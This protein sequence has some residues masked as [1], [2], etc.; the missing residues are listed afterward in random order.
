MKQVLV[1]G[2][3]LTARPL[4]RYLLDE[5]AFRVTLA[6]L[7]LAEAAGLVG[8]HQRGRSL[9]IDVMRDHQTLGDLVAEAELV[10]S[11]L[12]V[13]C[14]LQVAEQCVRLRRPLVTANYSSGLLPLHT[15]AQR[16]GV[17]LLCETGLDP[18]IDHMLAMQT[19]DKVHRAGGEVRSLRCYCGGLP[20]PESNDNPLGYKFSWTPRGVAM[21][22]HRDGRFKERGCVVEV[23]SSRVFAA[24][25][26]I[27]VDGL[28][29]F[30][31]YPNHDSLPYLDHYDIPEADTIYR[32]AVRNL[33]WCDLMHKLSQLGYFGLDPRPDL[34]GQTYR[35]VT[36]ALCDQ[37]DAGDLRTAAA[38]L[39]GISRES[40]VVQAMD[41][42]G[43]FGETEIPH[44]ATCLLDALV[45]LQIPRMSFRPG[46]RDMV[47]LV[48]EVEAE[49]P[50]HK[51][52]TTSTLIEYGETGGDSAMARTVG[53]TAAIAA[54]QILRGAVKTTGVQI[55]VFPEIY[56]PTL[57]ELD[58]QGISSVDS[59]E[60][61]PC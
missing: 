7:D 40:A 45:A 56:G 17:L 51:E 32:G 18:G 5:G 34:G 29:D 23:P 6:A 38:S 12:P 15:D 41:W 14:E 27:L 30:E 53:L 16:A 44:T 47:I 24:H 25:S 52:R 37:R 28:G 46:E 3:G 59:R 55:P 60:V 42:M 8:D 13:S 54:K 58:R 26:V 50:D 36:A 19:I 9:G 31:V 48:L 21:L 10:I 11:L 22:A 33:G 39:L 43:L 20:A 57:R 49:Y 1:L 4:V 2:A 61:I 35:E